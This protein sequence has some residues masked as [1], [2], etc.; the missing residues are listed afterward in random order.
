VPVTPDIDVRNAPARGEKIRVLWRG[1][2]VARPLLLFALVSMSACV[3]P[4]AP[5]FQDPPPTLEAPPYIVSSTPEIGSPVTV[6]PAGSVTFTAE[7]TDV[8]PG[9]TVYFI[10]ALDY[11]PFDDVN[12]RSGGPTNPILP[13]VDGRP[14]DGTVQFTLNCLTIVPSPSSG[15]EH[16]FSLLVADR[17]FS[18][19]PGQFGQ[20]MDNTGHRLPAAIWFVN[21]SCQ[22]PG[23]SATGAP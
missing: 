21:M 13:R 22:A 16:T 12:T 2:A 17:A 1:S 3:V 11:P 5:S 8:T 20:I 10:W 23:T 4:V 18:M 15:P 9:A 14:T 6:P 19:I 7:L